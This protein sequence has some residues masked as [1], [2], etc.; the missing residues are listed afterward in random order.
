MDEWNTT[1]LVKSKDLFWLGRPAI[2]IGEAGIWTRPWEW[3]KYSNSQGKRE[4]C[5]KV[6]SHDKFWCWECSHSRNSNSL[7][8]LKYRVCTMRFQID[9]V[10][11]WNHSDT[12]LKFGKILKNLQMKKHSFYVSK[13]RSQKY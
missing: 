2:F 1:G 8:W 5:G 11:K 13:L 7:E 10:E 12:D 9:K 3:M 4:I 6:F